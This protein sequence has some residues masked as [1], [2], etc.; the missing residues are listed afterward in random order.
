MA[1]TARAADPPL[2]GNAGR[3]LPRHRSR[4]R[5]QQQDRALGNVFWSDLT[6]LYPP[7]GATGQ[8]GDL[9]GIQ[10]RASIR[11]ARSS[12]NRRGPSGPLSFPASPPSTMRSAIPPR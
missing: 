6:D 9:G 8:V 11:T 7:H 1:S 12:G 10:V 3:A 5:Q 2:T 4:R